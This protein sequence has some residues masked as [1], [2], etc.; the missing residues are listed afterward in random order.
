MVSACKLHHFA[1]P[2][3]FGFQFMLFLDIEAVAEQN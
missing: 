1:L 2:S 3:T